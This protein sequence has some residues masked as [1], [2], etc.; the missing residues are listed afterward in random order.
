MFKKH[1]LLSLSHLQFTSLSSPILKDTNLMTFSASKGKKQTT[2]LKMRKLEF[3]EKNITAWLQQKFNISDIFQ[4]KA[5]IQRTCQ[6][7]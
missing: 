4:K 3:E 6:G 2:V 5:Y 7:S 1:W